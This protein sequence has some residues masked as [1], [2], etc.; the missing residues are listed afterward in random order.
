MGQTD[1]TAFVEIDNAGNLIYLGRLPTQTVSSPWRDMKVI[2]GYVYIGSEAANHGLQIFDMRKVSHV[3]PS[4]FLR[5]ML[6]LSLASHAFG[7]QNL[8]YQ[9]RPYCFVL[10]LRILPQHRCA[11]GK[12]HDLCRR[13]IP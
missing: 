1:G 5:T 12:E 3:S 13:N 6:S 8:Q 4:S 9:D 2:N 11:R 10:R 7:T